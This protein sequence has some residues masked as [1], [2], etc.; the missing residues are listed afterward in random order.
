MNQSHLIK[1]PI[2]AYEDELSEN[3]IVIPYRPYYSAEKWL[4]Y[5]FSE[6]NTW[7]AWFAI[8][9]VVG[10]F[11]FHGPDHVL[12][13]LVSMVPTAGTLVTSSAPSDFVG[14]SPAATNAVTISSAHVIESIGLLM[15]VVLSGFGW[16][17]TRKPTHI[18]LSKKGIAW[19]WRRWPFNHGK[20]IPWMSVDFIHVSNSTEKTSNRDAII[21]IDSEAKQ[22][23]MEFKLV[24]LATT[25]EKER[26]LRALNDWAPNV[27]RDARLMDVL[28]PPQD[29]SY[30]ELWMQALSAPPKRERLA[31]LPNGAVL[32]DGQY[33][34][35]RQI[36]VGG[37]GTAY[38]AAVE[39]G[40][41]VVLKEFILPVYV[42]ISVRRQALD[43]M[44]NEVEMLKRLD[45]DRVV[46]LIDFFIE[47]HRGYLVLERIDGDSLRTIVDGG[48]KF[49]EQ[50]TIDLA[51]QMCTIL[52]YLHSLSPPV[53][54][55]D[56]TPD[57]LILTRTGIL[58]LVDFNV[59][60][61]KEATATGTVVGKHAYIPPEQFRG[62]PNTQSDI[63]AMGASLFYILRGTDPEPISMSR[64]K[65]EDESISN[66]MDHIVARATALTLE[67]RYSDIS[68]M[69]TDFQQLLG[70]G[71]Q[72]STIDDTV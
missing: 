18:A 44:Q 70:C 8:L 62:K 19:E 32:K 11:V 38:L 42:E 10:F 35:D 40:H 14:L 27:R 29:H 64:P 23:A 72:A 69:R 46:K 51:E 24:G 45:N 36:G 7:K 37:Q 65:E 53:V 57:N 68:E 56:F 34:V 52:E 43:R 15:L 61:Q 4:E 21:S 48:R 13:Y 30:T 41:E 16:A 31:P 25:E 6:W 58:K 71:Q 17:H 54:H 50:E 3:E 1:Y 63:Y 12:S 33:T 47:D 26:F 28:T 5:R 20:L 66:G 60:Q 59:A 2:T 49:S 9:L 39:S 22:N 55:R 67:E